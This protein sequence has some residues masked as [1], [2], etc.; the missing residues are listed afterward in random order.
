MTSSRSE[1]GGLSPSGGRTEL[2][3]P[4]RDKG[5]GRTPKPQGPVQGR[6]RRAPGWAAWGPGVRLGPPGAAGPA[7]APG[8]GATCSP[9]RPVRASA[10]CDDRTLRRAPRAGRSVP[11]AP[12]GNAGGHWGRA[13]VARLPLPLCP[14]STGATAAVD[15]RPGT[16]GAGSLVV[17]QAGGSKSRGRRVCPRREPPPGR[18]R[19]LGLRGRTGQPS[20]SP[21]LSQDACRPSARPPGPAQ[22]EP[23]H[24]VT[25]G[26]QADRGRAGGS[27]VQPRRSARTRERP[28]A[29]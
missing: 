26:S 21:P 18:R 14:P 12:T 1:P 15:P 22:P 20:A 16:T 23:P 27:A 8:T 24:T 13:W 19:P 28:E 3:R 4:P 29:R 11:G 9:S 25:P 7:H 5:P 10:V 6:G 2:T 17:L